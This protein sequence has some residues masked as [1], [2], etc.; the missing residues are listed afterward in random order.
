MKLFCVADVHGFYDELMNVLNENKFD[1]NNSDHIFLSCGD[2]LDRGSQP[3]KCI[4]FVNNLP[5]NRKILIKGNHEDLMQEMLERQSPLSHD[6]HNGTFNTVCD[7][8]D[9]PEGKVVNQKEI[10]SL[11]FKMYNDKDWNQYLNDCINFYEIEDYIFVHGWIPYW[12]SS[13]IIPDN[14]RKLGWKEARWYNGFDC[15]NDGIKIPNKTIVCG[16][17]HTS[18]A[19]SKFHNDGSEFNTKTK[20]ANFGIFKDDGIIGLD[21]C[22]AYSGK[23]NCLVLEFN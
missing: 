9:I 7:M 15:W 1:I 2:L 18:Y 20:K 22:T 17:W 12:T 10:R 14:W 13:K 5:K 8:F 21:A 11:F 4:E 19:N 6:L 23:I 3:R 16:H